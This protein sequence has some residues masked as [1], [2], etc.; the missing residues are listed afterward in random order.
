MKRSLSKKLI[1]S[2]LTVALVT[3]LVVSALIRLTSGQSL[4]NLV[5]E[6]QTAMLTESMQTYYINHGNLDQFFENY[7]SAAPLQFPPEFP[8]GPIN[9]SVESDNFPNRVEFRGVIGFVDAQDNA[10]IPFREFQVDDIVSSETLKD[11]IPVKVDGNVIA[12]IIPDTS[13]QFKLSAEEILFLRRTTFAIGLAALAGILVSV[14]FGIIFSHSLLKPIKR[15]TEASKGLAKGELNQQV[16]VTSEDELGLL[17]TTFNQMS[18]DLALADEE[19]K[20]MT[21]D[22]THDLSTPL[23][24][25]SGYIEMLEGGEV[26]LNPERIEILKTEIGHLRRLVGDMTTLTQIESGG[27]EINPQPVLPGLLMEETYAIYHPIAAKQ[28]V[29]IQ[30]DIA[31]N[32]PQILVDEGRIL[33]VLKNLMENAL[34]YTPEGGKILL[35]VLVSDQVELHVADNGTGIEPDDLPYVFDRF[36]RADKARS[37][38]VGKMGLGLA[39]CKALVTAHGGEISVESA[40][41]GQGTTMIIKFQPVVKG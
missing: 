29:E 35:K 39:I 3:V 1:F 6:Q 31:E 26:T 18:T 38:N 2:Y 24:I 15:L 27:F 28:G 23:Q 5:M 19:R 16:P 13:L 25:I 22:I 8:Q 14:V 21:A 40:G 10:L 36:Y 17:T 41:K 7:L 20:R 11:S 32:S 4:M 12:Y 33:Q 37:T 34:R 30:L 9:R